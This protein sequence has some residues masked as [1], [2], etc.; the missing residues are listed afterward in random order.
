MQEYRVYPIPDPTNL[1]Q[2]KNPKWRDPI[3]FTSR[4]WVNAP[5]L[6]A[7]EALIVRELT[8]VHHIIL[9]ISGGF[10]YFN[11]SK[12]CL[13]WNPGLP[14]HTEPGH[15]KILVDLMRY[16]EGYHLHPLGVQFSVNMDALDPAGW[17]VEQVWIQG[18]Y[19]QN[20]NEVLQ[21][22]N[23]N[24]LNIQKLPDL[25]DPFGES[26][27]SSLNFRGE[28]RPMIPQRK[29][30]TVMP[31]GRRFSFSDRHIKW[32]GWEFEFSMLTSSGIQLYD[33]K[34]LKERI[35]YELSLQVNIL[36]TVNVDIFALIFAHIAI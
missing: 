23:Q 21:E 4:S 13:I 3:P 24:T 28:P 11:C 9:D 33:V 15:H 6:A 2:I 36:S 26:L 16:V 17:F 18:Q 7:M 20:F 5:Q 10:G 27:P 25:E 34:F 30:H 14:I 32:M 1:E 19:F 31:D 35:A 29:P 12:K 22:S 8:P